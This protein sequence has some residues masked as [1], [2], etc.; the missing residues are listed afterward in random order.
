MIDKDFLARTLV[1]LIRINSTNP[2]LTPGSPGEAEI[3]AYLARLMKTMGLRVKTHLL[4]PQRVNVVGILKGTGTGRSLMLNA[5]LDTVGVEGM[6]APFSGEIRDGRVYGRGSQD[7][8]AGLAAVLA[9]AGAI[10]AFGE[11]LRGDLIIAGVADEE[12]AS[13]GT[14]DLV[15]HYQADAAIVTEPTDL[16]IG[17]AHRGFIWFE[18]ETTGRA[19]HGSRFT[20]GIDAIV[21]MGRFLAGLD[22]LEKDLRERPPH[23]LAGPPSLHAS[24]I[25]G[26][27]ELSIYPARCLLAL[28][29][30][31]IPGETVDQAAQELQH[32]ID[33]LRDED[34]QFQA[35]VR[36]TMWRNPFEIDS[37]AEIIRLVEKVIT[38]Q[39]GRPPRHGGTSF[40]TDAA[41]LADAGIPSVLLGPIGAGLH[42]SEEWVDLQST[43]DL[44]EI[45]A[46][47]TKEFC[48]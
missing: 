38:R 48:A 17:R 41:I 8:K 40:W 43:V 28:E 27:S 9:A 34:S 31:T 21:H 26:G 14:A 15:K 16:V 35:S 33:R 7:M 11:K 5:H 13:A 2:S 20:E 6:P 36:S 23:V 24:T 25:H 44:A 22:R 1:D 45:L 30:R 42:S 46:A 32:I 37:S 29:R 18:V 10:I 47:T 19:A 4:A 39:L 12:F 3:G